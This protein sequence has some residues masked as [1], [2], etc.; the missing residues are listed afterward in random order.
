MKPL[1]PLK[2]GSDLD[3][4]NAKTRQ[5]SAVKFTK[6]LTQDQVKY[7]VRAHQ[8]GQFDWS[9][10]WGRCPDDEFLAWCLEACE[11]RMEGK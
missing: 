9:V 8:L 11:D 3:L 10:F 2:Y 6:N 7:F 5:D 4:K 1:N